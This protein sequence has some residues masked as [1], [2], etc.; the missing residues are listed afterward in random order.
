[1]TDNN[2]PYETVLNDLRAQ[3]AEIDAAIAAIERLRGNKPDPSRM[4]QAVPM[5]Q[6][7]ARFDIPQDAFFGLTILEAAKKYL[8]TMKRPQAT[9]QIVEALRNGGL[10]SSSRTLKQTVYSVLRRDMKSSTPSVI[11]VGS[12]WGLTEWY[13]GRRKEK[14]KTTSAAEDNNESA[15]GDK[16]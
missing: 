4:T 8:S 1:M 13:P 7:T 12:G 10:T 3:R 15:Q 6:N 2:D 11:K 16:E 9:Q 14:P 5:G